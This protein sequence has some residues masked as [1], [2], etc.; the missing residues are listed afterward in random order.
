M[1]AMTGDH[2]PARL[3]E[4]YAGG[5]PVPADA[6][7]ALEAHLESCG[8]CRERLGGLVGADTVALLERV[9]AGLD[10]EVAGG[11]RM[12]ARR[13]L[14]ARYLPPALLPR[15]LMTV[16]VVVAAMGLD[17]LNL[18]IGGPLPSVVLL[19]A[20]VAPL[21][22]VAAAWSR[23]LDPAHELV[24]ASPKAGLHMVLRR[25][26][27][28]LTV[29]V[30]LLAGAGAVV[31]TSPVGW[32]LPCLAL[33]ASALALGEL[34][35]LPRAAAGLALLWVALVVGPSLVTTELPVLLNRASLPGWAGLTAVVMVVLVIRRDAY[36]G[37]PSSR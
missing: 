20:P 30:P 22:G 18:L 1:A 15:L 33:T 19:V 17:L 31:G 32:L 10:A 13:R 8:L 2:V 29:V 24:V 16:L 28:V 26:L 6:V 36:T 14:R 37:L 35:G 23:G 3:L 12:P 5:T 27:A 7:W 9:R 34:V 21:L 4:E 25:T 11:P